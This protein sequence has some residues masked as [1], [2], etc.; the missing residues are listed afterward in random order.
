MLRFPPNPASVWWHREGQFSLL[1]T[2]ASFPRCFQQTKSKRD[3]ASDLLTQMHKSIFISPFP[4]LAP[5]AMSEMRLWPFRE[6][7]KPNPWKQL[8][9]VITAVPVLSHMVTFHWH[10]AWLQLSGL[11]A[12]LSPA[13]LSSSEKGWACRDV[14]IFS[15]GWNQY[16]SYEI[17]LPCRFLMRNNTGVPQWNFFIYK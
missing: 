3:S 6:S 12:T 2:L 13:I 5:A 16:P 17:L 11:Q 8:P 4:F 15:P 7:M 1:Q 10:F 9:Q 14:D